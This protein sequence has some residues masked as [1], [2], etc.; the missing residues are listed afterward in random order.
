MAPA[1][2]KTHSSPGENRV[3]PAVRFQWYALAALLLIALIALGLWY[4]VPLYRPWQQKRL[5][6]RGQAFLDRNE[7][8]ASALAAQQA[9]AMGAKNPAALRLMA[10]LAERTGSPDAVLWRQ[11]VLNL[12]ANDVQARLELATS[13]V[14]FGNYRLAADLLQS[15]VGDKRDTF[16]YHQSAATLALALRDYTQAEAHISKASQLDSK[17]LQVALNLAVLRL[18]SDNKTVAAEARTALEKVPE[19]SPLRTEA[20]RSLVNESLARK[21]WPRAERIVRTLLA[22]KSAAFSDRLLF[23]T[24]LRVSNSPELEKEIAVAGEAAS[25]DP[26]QSYAYWAWLGQNDMRDRSA[27]WLKALPIALQKQQPVPVALAEVYAWERSWANMLNDFNRDHWG[28][29]DFLRMAFITRALR[30]QNR[31]LA[32]KEQWQAAVRAASE[33]ATSTSMLTE[34]VASWGWSSEVEQLLW[35]SA[36]RFPWQVSAL[37]SLYRNYYAAG[38]T[39]GLLKVFG[40]MHQLDPADPI[41]SNNLSVVLALL[42]NDPERALSLATEVH[43]KHPTVPTFTCTYAYILHTRGHT[44]E[45]LKLL[46]AL[47]PE[48][49]RLPTRALYYGLMLQAKGDAAARNY[50]DIA[51][52]G[53]L[54]PEELAL[55]KSAQ[56]ARVETDK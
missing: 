36:N 38:N 6:A 1:L 54:L 15:I 12:N 52:Q 29:L 53:R 14:R 32:A 3:S 24:V 21:D 47:P 8:R 26:E 50:L 17:N 56:T 55:L 22:H 43:N 9:F 40:R 30:E 25:H 48:E 4:S 18:G 19:D 37:D 2:D 5:I 13:A 10:E 39:N 27:H 11:Q 20:L 28:R 16:A 34:K 44:D 33:G 31:E 46:E 41:T 7:F 51:S 45:G 49:L 23:L 35:I 42:G